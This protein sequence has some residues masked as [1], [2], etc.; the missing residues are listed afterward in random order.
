MVDDAP[1]ELA[2]G[3]LRGDAGGPLMQEGLSWEAMREQMDTLRPAFAL[4]AKRDPKL[5]VRFSGLAKLLGAKRAIAQKGASTRR[6]NKKAEAEGKPQVH[7]KVGKKRQCAAEKASLAAVGSAT[8]VAVAQV[9]SAAP[10][11]VA[12]LAGAEVVTPANANGV[13]NGAG[14]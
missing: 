8:P 7:G 13:V 11:A 12:P 9:A 1:A 10:A 4:A 6:A 14:H 3:W 2:M 5:I